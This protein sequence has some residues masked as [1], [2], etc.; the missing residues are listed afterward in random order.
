[1]DAPGC[2]YNAW[3]IWENHTKP[4]TNILQHHLI[5]LIHIEKEK[6]QSIEKGQCESLPEVKIKLDFTGK[7]YV[8][9]RRE[10]EVGNSQQEEF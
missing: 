7:G 8:K 1:M 10:S 4:G 6:V 5:K 9:K 2:A 3:N